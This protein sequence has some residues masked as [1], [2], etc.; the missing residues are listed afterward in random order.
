MPRRMSPGHCCCTTPTC[1]GCCNGSYPSEFDVTFTLTNDTCSYCG[2]WD[3]LY[4][5]TKNTGFCSWGY[6]SGYTLSNTCNG[7][8][9]LKRIR[10]MLR[11]CC[12]NSDL[13]GCPTS[14]CGDPQT[15]Y[16]I[17]LR[18]DL[19]R[20]QDCY[21]TCPPFGVLTNNWQDTHVWARNGVLLG[22]WTCNGASSYELPWYSRATGRDSKNSCPFSPG[23][24]TCAT[25]RVITDYL[26][27]S[28]S[29]SAYITAVP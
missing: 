22:S 8:H 20:E 4:I 28:N 29:A 17:Q 23:N 2:D 11:I 12:C 16:N 14:S 21:D 6:D 26:C 7:A 27:Q 10:V 9:P 3:G 18:V 24:Y 5:L 1:T 13:S 25:P 15:T 19:W